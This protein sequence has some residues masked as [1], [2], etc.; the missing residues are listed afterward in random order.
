MKILSIAND[1]STDNSCIV[2]TGDK[3]SKLRWL[4]MTYLNILESILVAWQYS[5]VDREI[6]EHQ[7]SY[8]FSSERGHSALSKFRSAAGGEK[9]FPAIEIFANHIEEKKKSILKEKANIV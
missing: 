7:F 8:L 1:L 6:I 5:I 3:V 4:V 9:S 2:L